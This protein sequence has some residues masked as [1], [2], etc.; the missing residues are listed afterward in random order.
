MRRRISHVAEGP[1]KE[2][3][4]RLYF[5]GDWLG[6][7]AYPIISNQ[8]EVFWLAFYDQLDDIDKHNRREN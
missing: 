7:F 2:N 1:T 8:S 5:Q 3:F 4:G 6:S